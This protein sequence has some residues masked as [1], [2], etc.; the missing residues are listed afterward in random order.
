MY[1]HVDR[2]DNIYISDINKHIVVRL[3]SNL[4]NGVVI[5]GNS[6]SGSRDYQLSKP[7][8]IFVTDN[9]TLYVADRQNNR[10]MKWSS[11]ASTGIRVAGSGTRGSS[12]SQLSLPAD[13]IVDANEYMYICDTG[14]S[15]IIRWGPNASFGTCIVA[16]TGSDG[17]TSTQLNWPNSFTFDRNGSLYVADYDNNR[18]Q[19]FQILNYPNSYNRPNINSNATWS[20]CGITFANQNIIGAK[21]RGIFIDSNDTIY[22][23][24]NNA[25]DQI[26]VWSK[27]NYSLISSINDSLFMYATPFVTTDGDIYFNSGNDNDGQIK[28]WSKSLMISKSVVNFSANCYGLFMDVKK[29]LYCSI[30]QRNAVVKVSLNNNINTIITIAGK[31]G[32]PG[33]GLNQFNK[34]WGIYVDIY[35]NLYVADANNNRILRFQPE[36]EFGEIVAGNGTPNADNGQHRIVRV[37]ENQFKC[38]VGCT[39]S[40]GSVSNQLYKP[41]A[42]RFDSIGNLY[43]TDEFNDR[44]QKFSLSINSCEVEISTTASTRYTTAVQS[45]SSSSTQQTISNSSVITTPNTFAISTVKSLLSSSILFTPSS[46]LNTT[47]IGIYCNSSGTLCHLINPCRKNETCIDINNN[48]DYNCSCLPGFSGK[49]CQFDHRFCK[50][51]TC[52]N[53][54]KQY[55]SHL[56]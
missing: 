29:N 43:I 48:Q 13:I 17:V 28:K 51:D 27:T 44:I 38:T 31:S 23:I 42:L 54:G 35:F 41:Y 45:S 12:L 11:G 25:G 30:Q 24:N 50:E 56:L 21:P 14:N 52:L 20:D 34:S 39:G 36:Q 33:S 16:C 26:L 47:N 3:S 18:V 46:C 7:Y 10:I 2:A 37:D 22:A 1:I 6:T 9:G 40:S 8:G 4:T 49:Q 53:G 32:S 19:K 15:R 5:A 55:H